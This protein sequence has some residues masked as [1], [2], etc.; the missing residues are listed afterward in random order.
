VKSVDHNH[1]DLYAFEVLEI[2]MDLMNGDNKEYNEGDTHKV[3]RIC[4]YILFKHFIYVNKN[5]CNCSYNYFL[6]I[7]EKKYIH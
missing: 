1:R 5:Q 6:D 7:F 3:C 4:C 2:G